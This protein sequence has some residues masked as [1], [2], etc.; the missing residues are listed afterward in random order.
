M[1]LVTLKF[2]V[3]GVERSVTIDRNLPTV[4]DGLA[5]YISQLSNVEAKIYETKYRN[6]IYQELVPVDTSDPEW[7]DQISYRSY[8]AVTMGKFIGANGDDLPQVA[9]NAKIDH[10]PV[11][12][13]GISFGYT[14]DELRKSIAMNMP[15]DAEGGKMSF[16]GFQEH[17]QRLAFNG[18]SSR[19]MYGLFNN[20]NVQSANS[21]V[22]W[23]TATNDEIVEDL[24]QP[25]LDVW[26]NSANVH[27]ADE[28]L[29]DSTRWAYIATTRMASGT[30]TTILEYFMKNNLFTAKTGGQLQIKP[31]LELGTA[32][33]GSVAR[34]IAYEKTPEN[35]VMKL[36]MPWRTLPPQ[37]KGLRIDV[38]SE[39]KVG[40]VEFR[41]PGSAAYRDAI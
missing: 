24:N 36:P 3:D 20:P 18:D 19:G 28:L 29:L 15:I 26:E 14:L 41:Y 8:D 39:Y 32:G 37:P 38:P 2:T 33:A 6:I 11:G 30:D 9:M 40:G 25:L 22:D 12:Y 1:N 13:G 31:V 34:M 7:V 4:D 17:C 35:L 21:V 16:R 27:L 23:S 5:F 10:I